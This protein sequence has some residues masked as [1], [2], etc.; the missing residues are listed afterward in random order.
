MPPPPPREPSTSTPW[1]V[2]VSRDH[3][4]PP[5]QPPSNAHEDTYLMIRISKLIFK[6]RH[7]P[8]DLRLLIKELASDVNA[9]LH[10][11]H[12][13]RYPLRY[14]LDIATRDRNSSSDRVVDDVLHLCDLLE[15]A[16]GTPDGGRWARET[17]R[18]A[19]APPHLYQAESFAS[20]SSTTTGQRRREDPSS[21]RGN[22]KRST[23]LGTSDSDSS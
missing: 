12:G 1:L 23:L 21:G 19:A 20:D 22:T 9:A 16:Y 5:R 3:R 15:R 2:V 10:L 14:A 13:G 18:D 6:N 8:S 7:F 4:Q 11:L 17:L